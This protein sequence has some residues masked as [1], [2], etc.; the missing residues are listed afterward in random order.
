MKFRFTLV[1]IALAF[2]YSVGFGQMKKN[3]RFDQ[4][5]KPKTPGI[6]TKANTHEGSN[7]GW[8]ILQD[9]P[10][11]PLSKRVLENA[12]MRMSVISQDK[13]DRPTRFEC[14]LPAQTRSDSKEFWNDFIGQRLA[15]EGT[16]TQ[17]IVK[18]N[19]LDELGIRHIRM[20]QYFA[21]VPIYASEYFIHLYSKDQKLMA[22]GN[23]EVPS[24]APVQARISSNQAYQFAKK[25]LRDVEKIATDEV[26]YGIGGLRTG[27]KSQSLEYWKDKTSNWF[28]VYILDIMPQATERYQVIVDA[29]NGKV[30]KSSTNICKLHSQGELHSHDHNL[31]GT[32]MLS[33]LGDEPANGTDLLGVNRSFRTWKEGSRY[34]MI[35][36]SRSMFNPSASK[37]PDE[38][39]GAIFTIDALNSRAGSSNFQ[40]DHITS[41]N[42]IWNNPTAISAHY[43]AGKAYDYYLGTHQRNSINGEKGTIISFINVTDEDGKKMDNA[44]WNG[45][46]MFYGNGNQAFTPLAKGLDVAG[47]EMSHGV[48]QNSANLTY[49]NESGALNESF[50]DIFGAMIDREDWKMGEDVVV[51]AYF[52]SGALRD[53]SN[54]HNGASQGNY[55][56]QPN[57]VNEQYKGT[58]DNG[59]VHINSGITNYAYYLF[60]QEM[61]KNMSEEQAKIIAEKVYY[62]ALTSYLTR[63]SKFLDLRASIEQSC[64]DLYSSNANV[65]A[66]AQSAFSKVGIGGGGSTGGGNYQKDL[67]ANPG[68]EYIV[69]TDQNLEGVYLVDEQNSKFFELSTKSIISKPSVTDDGT[70]IYYVASDNS[71]HGLFFN[72]QTSAYQDVDLDPGNNIYRNVVISKDGRLLAALLNAEEKIIHVY[73]FVSQQWKSFTLY[74]PTYTQG[75]STGEVKYADFMDFDLSSQYILYD[76][77]SSIASNSGGAT[78]NYWDIGFLKVFESS[79]KTFSD[80]K[81]EKLFSALPE[82]TSIGNAIFS[83]N[84]PYIIAFDYVQE[85]LFSTNYA[86]LG[87]NIET[88]ETEAIL[89]NRSGTGYPNYNVLDNRVIYED[90]ST[91]FN[92]FKIPIGGTKISGSGNPARVIDAARW[93]SYFGLGKRSLINTKDLPAV[94][95]M[96]FGPNPTT[97]LLNLYLEM[98]HSTDL[99]Y[100]LVDGS[101]KIWRNGTEKLIDGSNHLQIR[102]ADLTDG[103]YHLVL[104]VDNQTKTLS[105]FK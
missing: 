62:R 26:T 55:A 90:E 77:Y 52:P 13:S 86:I 56:W 17:F 6:L 70:E 63:S 96:E 41:S 88:G 93:G 79:S 31:E 39:V 58:E 4:T 34:Y 12:S 1:L 3:I 76:S 30:L 80:G 29:I 44:F 95:K 47:H 105:I 11:L 67:S 101:G 66:A 82:N 28:L 68:K 81:I 20:Q 36:G 103:L 5:S 84:S 91:Q 73:D 49:E 38:P 50:A 60:V 40:A 89:D 54:P 35:D 97:E 43:N 65:L 104:S 9:L 94:K 10:S 27:L 102:V 22:H 83:K 53:L 61:A 75:V 18:R 23:A 21:G 24:I 57:H 71:M 46:A 15:L 33:P 100:Q 64:K 32:S 19:E 48:I 8:S 37:M 92:L 99:Q 78:V 25:H 87:T 59:G 42:N 2:G 45:E 98:D 51:K 14:V 72:S 74:N 7:F 16:G 85:D 69:C